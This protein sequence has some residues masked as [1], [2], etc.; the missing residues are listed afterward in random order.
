MISVGD[1]KENKSRKRD[2]KADAKGIEAKSDF[3][4]SFPF[5]NGK[6]MHL[7]WGKGDIANRI[8]ICSD[9]KV[10]RRLS[11]Y[12]D[13]PLETIEIKSPRHFLIYTGLF[14]GVPIS[15]ISSGIGGPMIDFTMREAK[16]ILDGPMAVVRF[17]TCCSISDCEEGKIHF[18]L[19]FK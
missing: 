13:N 10:V 5:E 8:I 16:F 19:F 12:F 3:R 4:S 1:S 17:G 7:D 11:K 9:P 14:Q 18:Y 15:I 6:T 2:T